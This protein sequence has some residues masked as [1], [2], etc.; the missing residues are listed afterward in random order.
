MVKKVLPAAAPSRPHQVQIGTAV[1]AQVHPER[2]PDI[3]DAC[4]ASGES[5]INILACLPAIE[6]EIRSAHGQ[7]SMA[8]S[9]EIGPGGTPVSTHA[10]FYSCSPRWKLGSH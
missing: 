4:Q 5:H 10:R 8:V 1:A 7:A 9:C 3:V 6:G 2:L